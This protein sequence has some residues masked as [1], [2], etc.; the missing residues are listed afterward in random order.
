VESHNKFKEINDLTS[1]ENFYKIV[2]PYIKKLGNNSN[3]ILY[4]NYESIE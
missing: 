1:K 2:N 3:N 4:L